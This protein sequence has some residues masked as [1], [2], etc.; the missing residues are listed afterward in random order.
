MIPLLVARLIGEED[1]GDFEYVSRIANGELTGARLLTIKGEA[2]RTT[3]GTTAVVIDTVPAGK[4]WY[5]L[6]FNYFFDEPGGVATA[7]VEFPTGTVIETYTQETVV[8]SNQNTNTAGFLKSIARGFKAVAGNTI[9]V[10][11][12]VAS[13]NSGTAKITIESMLILEVPTGTSPKLT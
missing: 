3:V 6:D 10:N 1:V 2:T 13:I 5:L 9:T 7:T 4:D 11:A 8:G 12:I